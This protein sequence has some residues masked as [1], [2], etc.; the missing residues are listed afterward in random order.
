MATFTEMAQSI[1]LVVVVPTL[2][3]AS[4]LPNDAFDDRGN[5]NPT[6]PNPL[7]S[8]PLGPLPSSPAVL[9]PQQI[10]IQDLFP[11]EPARNV[12]LQYRPPVQLTLQP[13][14]THNQQFIPA[15]VEF[16]QQQIPVQQTFPQLPVQT[17]VERR[18]EQP[19]QIA[20]SLQT[21]H[22]PPSRCNPIAKPLVDEIEDGRAYHFSWCHDGGLT[23]TW[24][25]AVNY[26]AALGNGFQAISIE[27][28][29]EQSFVSRFLLDY[30]VATCWT[31]GSKFS[32]YWQ[33]LS[34]I[35]SSYTN[36]SVTGRRGLP[37]PDNDEGNEQCLAVLN[38][39]YND[40]VTWHDSNCLSPRPVICETAVFYN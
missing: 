6:I 17:F 36:W 30:N 29:R 9:A 12:F 25:Q 19:T 3:Y 1:L 13:Q 23:Y 35:S 10:P 38:N 39:R 28:G 31:S 4:F 32:T 26:C 16:P 24:K 33:W 15:Q 18:T 2:A 37:Q 11:Q 40:G 22:I 27:S 14:L 20:S 34:R 5:F 8:T 7:P 21:S